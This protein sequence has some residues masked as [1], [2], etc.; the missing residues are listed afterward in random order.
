MRTE[1]RKHDGMLMPSW[2]RRWVYLAASLCLL[3]GVLWLLFDTFVQH[4]GPFGPEQHPLQKQWLLL[5]G[6]SAMLMLWVLGMVWLA[7]VKRGWSGV[8]NRVSGATVVTVLIVLALTGW[9]LYYL[10]DEDLRLWASRVHW[11]IG[12]MFAVALPLH[13]WLGRKSARRLR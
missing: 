5:H 12:L 10:G 6:A 4:E 8:R 13:I 9:G 11:L 3:S 2:M 7:H 1:Q